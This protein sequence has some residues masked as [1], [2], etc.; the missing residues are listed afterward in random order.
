[1]QRAVP[2]LRRPAAPALKSSRRNSGVSSLS[3]FSSPVSALDAW[4]TL[5]ATGISYFVPARNPQPNHDFTFRLPVFLS[6]PVVSCFPQPAAGQ[7]RA[8]PRPEDDLERWRSK[9]HPDGEEGNGREK[10]AGTNDSP[11][12]KVRS[13]PRRSP[14]GFA[15]TCTSERPAADAAVG[16]PRRRTASRRACLHRR[17]R[18][19]TQ[20]YDPER[21]GRITSAPGTLRHEMIARLARERAGFRRGTR[22]R[23]CSSIAEG[24]SGT[25]MRFP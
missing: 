24:C 12:A 14:A 7:G 17:R 16:S 1:M 3:P 4:V 25:G 15:N 18:F 11:A 19:R 5:K 2:Q 23:F 6:T 22:R 10:A 8:A 9:I 13:T 20:R 21:I